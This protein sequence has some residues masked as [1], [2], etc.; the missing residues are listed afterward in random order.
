MTFDSGLAP[1]TS[2]NPVMAQNPLALKTI[3]SQILKSKRLR[4]IPQSAAPA[5]PHNGDIWTTSAGAF[6]RI[7]GTTVQLGDASLTSQPN[8]A[9]NSDFGRRTVWGLAMADNFTDTNGYVVLSGT[10]PTVIANTLTQSTGT[11]LAWTNQ[12]FVWRDGRMSATFKAAGVNSDWEIRWRIGANDYLAVQQNAGVF[13]LWKTVGGVA[14]S[15]GSIANV[16]TINFWY[17]LEIEKQGTTVIAKFYSTLGGVIGVTKAASTLV[18]TLTGTASD[19]VLQT[20]AHM[21]IFSTNLVTKWGGIAASPGGVYVETWLP[22]T[23][24][25]SLY[26]TLGGQAVGLDE[27]ADAGPI[28]KS[29]ALRTYIPS[30][31]RKIQLYYL[32]PDGSI[33]PTTAY[34]TSAYMKVSGK[35][36]SGTLAE[37]A[38]YWETSAG[39]D[40][41]YDRLGDAGETTWTQKTITSTTGSTVRRAYVVVDVNLAGT[42]TGFAGFMCGQLERGAVATPWR[43]APSDDA[44]LVW[45][46]PDDASVITN[47]S[48]TSGTFAEMD[49]SN[50][51]ANIFLPWDADVLVSFGGTA[52]N[53]GLNVVYLELRADA[54]ATAGGNGVSAPQ[55]AVANSSFILSGTKR[56]RCAVGKHRLAAL[57]ATSAGT[58]TLYDPPKWL[59]ITASRGK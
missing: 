46:M 49:S 22:E 7:N 32:T 28:G 45:S 23:M 21:F 29:L 4:L 59:F 1:Q 16:L 25:V 41:A 31:D 11:S 35:G 10:T 48:T 19:A 5:S 40:V 52:R 2:I 17:W 37:W 24:A 54:S 33:A 9:L 26:G 42:A 57:W 58:A 14:T 55:A 51:A 53:S 18:Q 56:I 20:G 6:A 15:L 8:L 30:A 34:T 12:D 47:F 13:Q 43:N 27:A 44:P 3:I 36:G 50:L 39:V 38:T